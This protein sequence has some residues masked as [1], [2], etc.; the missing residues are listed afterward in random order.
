MDFMINNS[1][2]KVKVVSEDVMN[3][4]LKE[5][6]NLGCTVYKTQTIMLLE[7]QANIIKTLKHELTHAWLYEYG[8]NQHDNKEFNCEDV[9][10]IVSSINDF[11]TEKTEMFIAME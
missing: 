2:W 11:I 10:E 1:Q 7:G 4:F 6:D 3:N 9:C 8:H 5:D